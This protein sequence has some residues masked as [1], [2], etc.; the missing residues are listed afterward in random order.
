M[1]N[2]LKAIDLKCKK[3]SL[4]DLIGE[5]ETNSA[6]NKHN[7]VKNSPCLIRNWLVCLHSFDLR[8]LEELAKV[9]A[10]RRQKDFLGHAM[11]PMTPYHAP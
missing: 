11:T 7:L 8:F 10:K 5:T 6:F 2:F 4:Q 1:L 3:L 9:H